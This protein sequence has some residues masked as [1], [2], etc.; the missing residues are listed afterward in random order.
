MSYNLEGLTDF[1]KENKDMIVTKAVLGSRT[2]PYVT[3]QP[4]I[5]TSE[6]L[7]SFVADAVLQSG[8]CG[9][10]PAGTTKLA[11]RLITVTDLMD[12][13]GLC[14]KDLEKKFLQLDVAAGANNGAKDM[15]IEELYVQEKLK[16]NQRAVDKLFWRGDKSSTN[17]RLNKIDGIET[18]L[19][20][21]IPDGVAVNLVSE[22]AS[23]VMGSDYTTVEATA[24]GFSDRAVVVIAGTANY[25]G[26]F[27][28]ANVTTDTFDIPV[29]FVADE[30]AVGTA[31]PPDQK[32]A[33]TASVKDD[34]DSLIALLPEEVWEFD[35]NIVAMSV[36]NFNSLVKE[37]R[38]ENNFHFTGEQGNYSF[39]FPGYNLT[40]VAMQ[41]MS[42]SN[43]LIMYNKNNMYWGT[44]LDSDY[45]SAEF[46]WDQSDR[47]WK[48]HMNYRLGA[49]VAF[50]EEVVIAE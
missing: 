48:W 36:A 5:K 50:P 16:A 17:N 10:N 23:T 25:N 28:I 42:G 1:V 37:L 32:I 9:W 12:Q 11:Q 22:A 4:G 43:K 19:S 39:Q 14:T 18:I 49:Q 7:T 6:A 30:G 15:P 8:A 46:Y 31:T 38:D 47:E 27:V 29:T 26:T 20:N 33:R 35:D 21:D 44:D 2:I 45:E 34:I 3:V 13:E 40:V 24:H 41:G